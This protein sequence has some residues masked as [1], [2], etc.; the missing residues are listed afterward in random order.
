[1]YTELGGGSHLWA[2]GAGLTG[3]EWVLGIVTPRPP[4]W[5]ITFWAFSPKQDATDAIPLPPGLH[6]IIHTFPPPLSRFRFL[7]EAGGRGRRPVHLS[8]PENGFGIRM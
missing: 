7:P 6:F 5:A 1:M 2:G 8:I 4:A 3:R